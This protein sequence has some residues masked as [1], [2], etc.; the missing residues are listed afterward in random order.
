M[1]F[2]EKK[3]NEKFEYSVTDIFGTI[4]LSSAFQLDAD[5]LDLLVSSI[6]VGMGN[7]GVYSVVLKDITENVDVYFTF[8]RNVQ[9]EDIDP[10]KEKELD[11]IIKARN[12][13]KAKSGFKNIIAKRLVKFI[14]KNL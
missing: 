13:P 10:K 12:N 4:E 5:T 2:L 8:K 3:V 7:E 1:T 11:K 9:W 14:N 6:M